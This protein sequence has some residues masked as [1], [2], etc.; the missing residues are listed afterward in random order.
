M[1]ELFIL[2]SLICAFATIIV[3]IGA[4]KILVIQP[5]FLKLSQLIFVVHLNVHEINVFMTKTETVLNVEKLTAFLRSMN[6]Y[7]FPIYTSVFKCTLFFWKNLQQRFRVV[8][9]FEIAYRFFKIVKCKYPPI[10]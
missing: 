6:H 2:K 4:L 7:K 1:I 9:Y 8:I 3:Y 5:C 10:N